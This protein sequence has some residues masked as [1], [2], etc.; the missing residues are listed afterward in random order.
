MDQGW[1]LNSTL[2]TFI[3]DRGGTLKGD[4]FLK[5]YVFFQQITIVYFLPG[6]SGG[7]LVF[8]N[9]IIGILSWGMNSGFVKSKPDQF[10][11]VSEFAEWIEEKTGIK[12]V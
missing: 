4:F 12:A 2:C 9:K 10:T 6:D 3:G 8:D 1:V 11:R 5:I 7:A